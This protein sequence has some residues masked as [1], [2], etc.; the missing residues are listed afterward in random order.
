MTQARITHFEDFELGPRVDF[1][2]RVMQIVGAEVK[3][4]KYVTVTNKDVSLIA[5][6]PLEESS[7]IATANT[8]VEVTIDDEE[9][10]RDANGD[11]ATVTVAKERAMGIRRAIGEALL[12]GVN[13]QEGAIVGVFVLPFKVSAWYGP[14]E[15]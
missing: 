6:R 12:G 9:W 11:L 2:Y 10:P 1:A 7:T 13:A 5:T 15:Q 4:L 8:E 3:G 14:G